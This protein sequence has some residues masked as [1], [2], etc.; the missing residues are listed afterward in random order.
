MKS[1]VIHAPKDL[2]VE[3]HPEASP[4]PG[5]I[6][7][8][9]KAGGICGSDL[10]YYLHGGFGAVR[11]REP[12]VLGH[13]IAGLVDALGE[14]VSGL[15]LGQPVAVNPS[16]PCGACRQCLAGRPNHCLDMRFYGS[17]MRLPH[18]QGGFSESLVC[19][20]ARAVP[21]PE[22]MTP[23]LAAFAEPLSVCL[24]AARQAGPLL[25][26]RVLVTGA[27][28]IGN[29]AIAVARHAGAREI[30]VS[31]L[32]STPLLTARRMGADRT[33]SLTE[34]ADALLPYGLDKGH[35]DVVFEASGSGAALGAAIHAARPQ[36]TIVQLGLGGDVSLPL[37]S[38]VAKEI[39]LR[40]TFRF[41]AEFALAV[42]VLARGG[43][44]P[45][46]LL[47]ATMPAAEAV[48]AFELAADRGRAMKVQLAF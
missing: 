43:I 14:G 47:T 26:A 12:M 48:A 17:A 37:S 18:V 5:Q 33:H 1:I 30:V 35:F 21:L 41:H 46:P 11:L 44:D 25:G 40:G 23:E 28:P 27:G 10:H 31:D 45:T 6:R 19:E 15:A 32:H 7:I 8:R 42:E 4:G 36:A 2:R 38:L 34:D 24:H 20:A 29:L 9:I 22:G 39:T 13:E 3:D 16:L